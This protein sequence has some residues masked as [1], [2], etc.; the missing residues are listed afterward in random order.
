MVLGP[1]H[2]Q[3]FSGGLRLWVRIVSVPQV[4]HPGFSDAV[5]AARMGDCS[6]APGRCTASLTW[7]CHS[8]SNAFRG[9]E[10]GRPP[11]PRDPLA[12]GVRSGILNVA[13][14]GSGDESRREGR[15]AAHLRSFRLLALIAGRCG[16][17]PG[18]G[19]RGPGQVGG[20]CCGGLRGD[21]L[22]GTCTTRRRLER[23]RS[24]SA[25]V[26]TRPSVAPTSAT[27]ARAAGTCSSQ[28]GL[29]PELA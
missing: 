15:A 11:G 2:W 22:G 23:C 25:A 1:G 13:L 27:A 21:G 3:A 5:H 16:P 7:T 24:Q 28:S 10:E 19:V 14:W 12:H 9:V 6:E 29:F 4:S 26:K 18:L 8:G 20:A 17:R